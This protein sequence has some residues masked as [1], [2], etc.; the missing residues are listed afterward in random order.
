MKTLVSA[1]IALSVLAGVAT[2]ASA[3][4]HQDLL[5]PAGPPVPLTQL[6][7]AA[8]ARPQ[9]TLIAQPARQEGSDEIL[10]KLSC[11]RPDSS[12]A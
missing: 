1:L 10:G 5:G 11:V 6:D 12:S 3:L 8:A 9:P 7:R 2:S 4:D